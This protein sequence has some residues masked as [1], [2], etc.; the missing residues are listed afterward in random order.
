ML[1]YVKVTGFEPGSRDI[2]VKFFEDIN[3]I[4]GSN[5]SGK[6]NFLKLIWYILSGNTSIA[7]D[8]V[9][10]NSIFLKTSEFRIS[11]KKIQK[12]L[13]HIE[14]YANGEEYFFADEHDEDSEFMMQSAIDQA[15]EVISEFSKTIFF[16]T[17]RRIEGGFTT[18]RARRRGIMRPSRVRN[19]LEDALESLSR[20]L[21]AS[22]HKF[23]TSI[24]TYD[25]ST[26][27]F[28]EY[29]RVSEVISKKQKIFSDEMINTIREYHENK[30]TKPDKSYESEIIQ[31]IYQKLTEFENYKISEMQ[32]FK[33][34]EEI[35]RRFFR[36][37]NV[38]ITDNFWF[39]DTANAI[40]SD[41]LSAGEKQLLSFICYNAFIRNTIFFIDEPE[42]SLHVDWQRALFS[43]LVSQNTGNQFITATHSPFIYTKYHDKEILIGNDRGDE[44]DVD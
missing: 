32:R 38:S 21:S 10:F 22:G 29:S 24:A 6:T 19:E 14:L 20:K 27:L 30:D 33:E 35:V 12:N 7:V 40:N 37:S 28:N 44:E 39:G 25:I 23:V 3:I 1:E 16:P 31:D 8:E 17:F 11:I 4:T 42:L 41:K 36:H 43:I 9:P 13:Y 34:I 18:N 15:D 26:L 5:G 2:E